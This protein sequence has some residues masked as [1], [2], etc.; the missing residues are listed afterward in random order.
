MK[1][2][3][4]VSLSLLVL[5]CCAAGTW[6]IDV[7]MKLIPQ[8]QINPRLSSS[9]QALALAAARGESALRTMAE[10]TGIELE[11]DRID[12][13]IEPINGRVRAIDTAAVRLLGG[14]VEARSNRL[15]R[16]SVPVDRLI[17]LADAASGVAYIREPYP[18]RP[19]AVTSQGVGLTGADDFHDA[20][21]YGQGVK[22]AIIDLGFDGLASAQAAGELQNVVYTWDYIH[23]D[24]GVEGTGIVHGTGV[25]EVVEDMA[26]QAD[27]YLLLISDSVD[28]DNATQY[29]LDNGIDIINHSVAWFNTNFYDGTGTVAGIANDARDE[30]ILWVNAAGNYGD[31]GHWQGD[32][33]DGDGDGFNEF[34][35]SDER[36]RIYLSSSDAI[37]VYLTWDDWSF[38]DQDYDLYLYNSSGEQ[39]AVSGNW[40]SGYQSPIEALY[41]A[42][43]DDG[44]HTYTDGYYDI[45]IKRYSA[46]GAMEMEFFALLDSGADTGLEYHISGSSISAPANSSKVLAVG[47]ISYW[48][49]T[50]GPQ[51]SYSSIGPSNT[52]LTKP[53]IGGPASVSNR[54]YGSFGGTSAASPHVAGAAAL[55]LSEDSGRSA[56]D[57]QTLLEG[58]AID[59]GT[60]GKDNTYG[61][62]RLNLALTS[63]EP[64]RGYWQLDEEAG[65]TA[66]DSSTYGNDGTIVGASWTTSVDASG[67]LSFDG[68]DD[69]VTVANAASL[70]PT[71]VLTVEVWV[72]LDV[73]GRKH[74]VVEK[75]YT[76]HTA[77]Y[78]E[79]IMIVAP[80]GEFTFG[81]A[82]NGAYTGVNSSGAGLT[83]GVWYHLAGV[84]DG[85]NLSLYVDGELKGTRAVGGGSIGSYDTALRLGRHGNLTTERLQGDLDEVRITAGA[86]GPGLF[87]LIPVEAA[88]PALVT[89]FVATDGADRQSTL[90]WTNPGDSDLAQVTMKRKTGSYPTSHTDG[91]TVYDSTSPT[92]G[93]G[94]STTDT[95][96]TNGTTYYYAVFGKDSGG[97]WNDTVTAGQN[98][99]TGTPAEPSGEEVGYW[100]F[101]EG[102]GATAGDS[103]TYG[104]DGTIV[105]AS[106]TTSV[107][108]SGALSFD[109]VDDGVTVANAAS[110]NPTSVLTVEVWVRLDVTGRKHVVVEKPYTSHTAPYYEYIMIVAPS[111]EF[112]F[113]IALN[114]AYTG[115]NSSGAGL[116]AGVWYHLA[117][118]Y[119]G[120]N[121]S[122]YVD[123]ELKGTRAV[124]GGSIGSYDTALRL[125]R[126]GNLT[127]ERLQG[128]LDEVRIT[129]GALGPGLFNLIPVE[130]APPALVTNFVATDGADRQSTLTWTNPG[131]SDLAQVTM[132]RKTG[133][134]P[135]SHT[136]GTTVY[137]STSPTPGAGVSTTDT[138][139]TNGTTY[140]YA[141]FGKD[142]GGL[143]NDTVTAG[144]NADTGTPAEPSGEEVGYWQFN[145][146]TGATA[147]DSSTYGNDGTIVGASW[148]TSVDAS[149]A[150]S[151]DGVDDGVTV[152]NAASLNPTSVLTVEV[153]VRLDVMGRKHVVVE[154]PYTSHTA[155]YYEYI[156]IV[157]PSGEF[158]FGI[159]LN[160]AY[161]GVNSSGAGLTAG[162]WYHLA[163]VYDG[164][165]LSLYVDGELKGTRAVGGGSIGSYDTA[166][167]LGRHGNL[168]TERLQGDLDE[169][170]I[171]AGALGPAEFGLLSLGADVHAQNAD[172]IPT[173]EVR[174][175]P[176]PVRS[177][178]AIFE[179]TDPAAQQMQVIVRSA[180]GGVVYDSG[181]QSGSK[182]SWNTRNSQEGRVANGVY[183]YTICWI[184]S[185]DT[186]RCSEPKILFVGR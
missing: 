21:Y 185:G 94:V 64:L 149:G 76:S 142:S 111:G 134:Y 151:F 73:T 7:P 144:Q 170:R 37:S 62:G 26:P 50:T 2:M 133:S 161:T 91:T 127:T 180:A 9:L 24:S 138:G 92:P 39:V 119:D 38:S 174:V 167:R 45:A 166:L 173:L 31:D 169:V 42:P 86:L 98:A 75:P 85:A 137:D 78:Y 25:A 115:V 118:V 88:P 184:G 179:T 160:G 164:A 128:D 1:S 35:G 109:G 10:Q 47:A 58:S 176:N 178:R 69:G 123:G 60:A 186:I 32:F 29:C 101:N 34:S 28:L 103:S 90:T 54:T 106:W 61:S 122:L 152:A 121:L 89:N 124:G 79:Y 16:V 23:G 11:G 168:T 4:V 175:R 83:A 95:G 51:A 63:W 55:L 40:Q 183:I 8:D 153:W 114:G 113:G 36:N 150:L 65:G 172:S 71:S 146:G 93:A 143:W 129:A 19:L 181:W 17:E 108:A 52:G 97:L 77:P 84:Y 131:D 66:G 159:A 117:G 130:A 102:T 82:L 110:L 12:V 136:D 165:N 99:D 126:H 53:D 48:N 15:M 104:N 116:T 46:S 18:V 141:V 171:T 30:G 154:K 44:D 20:G 157:A 120:A 162:V 135:T 74:V 14:T 49:W 22:V 100:Q 132:K 105:G 43:A 81:I 56:N 13:I 33:A 125:G 87:N 107:D 177:D 145:E 96:L 41:Y 72:R 67:A 59:M 148:T 6:G 182:I 5:V 155:P 139:L 163:G 70:N 57:L 112:T 158:T 156:M 80:S 27:L 147:G 3:K 140:Y 68:V